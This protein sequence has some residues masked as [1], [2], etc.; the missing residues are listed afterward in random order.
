[1]APRSFE[2]TVL[3]HLDAAFNYARWL[4]KNDAEAEDVVQ[5]ACVR[6]MRYLPTLRDSDARA[7]LFT[8]VRNTWYSR[9]SRSA[10]IMEAMPLDDARDERPDEALGPEALLLQQ[11]AVARVRSA[12]ERLDCAG[13]DAVSCAF[14][15]YDLD[16]YVDRELDAETL[17]RVREHLSACE[18][19]RARVAERETLGRLVRATSSYVAPPQLRARVGAQTRRRVSLHHLSTWAAAAVLVVAVGGGFLLLRSATMRAD[20]ATEEAVNSHV[21]SLM[22]DHLFDVKST[23]QHTVKPWF[24][25]KL[26]FSPPVA[27]LASAGFPLVGGRLEYLDGRAAAALVYQRRQHTINVFVVPAGATPDRATVE[28]RSVRGF[29]VRQWVRG[30]MA[31]WAVSDLNDAELTDFA[32]ALQTS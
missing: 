14:I 6:A 22:A 31:F 17:A 1:M 16:G 25:G 26:D 11:H 5:D 27:D 9:L 4:T 12:L 7:W 3:P 24:L 8:I 2:E 10:T 21:R 32:R 23:D 15:E 29:H 18:S 30:G 20:A 13:D 19:C 28:A